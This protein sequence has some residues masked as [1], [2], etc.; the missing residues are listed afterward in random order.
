MDQNVLVLSKQAQAWDRLLSRVLP[1]TTTKVSGMA[2]TNFNITTC[3]QETNKNTP[4]LVRQKIHGVDPVKSER[5]TWK[6]APTMF[7]VAVRKTHLVTL[8]IGDFG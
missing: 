2:F 4:V 6:F 8:A 3:K 7:Y 5:R 1:M